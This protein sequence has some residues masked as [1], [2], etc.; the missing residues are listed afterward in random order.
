[1]R[2]K[3]KALVFGSVFFSIAAVLLLTTGSFGSDDAG[4]WRRHERQAP[5]KEIGG[6]RMLPGG[7]LLAAS[8]GSFH[9]YDG[10]HWK[11]YSYESSILSN[12]IPFFSDSSGKLYFNDDG[13]AVWDD[14]KITRYDSIRL[15][16]PLTAAQAGNGPVYFG[17]YYQDTGGVYRFDGNT[18][19]RIYD[20]QVRSLAVDGEGNV[21]ASAVP[22]GESNMRLLMYGNGTWSDRTAEIE[23]LLP[24]LEKSL[25]VQAAPDG[26]VWVCNKGPYGV[27]REGK[28][29][30]FE[31]VGSCVPV[32]LG[33]DHKGGVW[34]YSPG[35][36]YH[37]DAQ[38]KWTAN[39][40]YQT[41]LPANIS[42][43][44]ASD[45]A[46]YTFQSPDSVL[47]STNSG[48]NWD[49]VPDPYDLGS[50]IVTCV[51]YLNDGR[52]LCGHGVK[53]GGWEN[54]EKRGLS[55][56]D[57]KTWKNFSEFGTYSF[58][59]VYLMK[60]SPLGL[61]YFYSDG[62]YFTYDG[63]TVDAVDS[64]GTDVDATDM[65]WDTNGVLW[66]ATGNGLVDMRDPMHY[67]HFTDVFDSYR[68]VYNICIDD[69]DKMYM[70]T[71]STQ[72]IMTDLANWYQYVPGAGRAV[73]D[74]AVEG[75]GK[76]WGARTTDLAWW[77]VTYQQWRP[78][79]DF[80]DSNR[81]AMIDPQGRIWASGYGKTGYY[82]DGVFRSFPELARSASNTMDFAEDGRIALNSFNRV[83]S[84]YY[85]IEEFIPSTVGV[86]EPPRPAP[87]LT[88]SSYPN[89]FNPATTIQFDL[90]AA[91]QVKIT[92]YNVTG[93]RVKQLADRRFPAGVNRVE[94]DSR[95]DS[96]GMASSGVYFYRIET[97][98]QVKTGKMLLMR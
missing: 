44:A 10:T 72:V 68:F 63:R 26:S 54:S 4:F 17:S 97:G 66:L 15:I 35:N 50:N 8:S 55:I 69:A 52:L 45:S 83:R 18:A 67:I 1:M 2:K 87:F 12:H 43:L 62:G 31:N 98:R 89:P 20:G 9:I 76:L 32:S 36:L 90:P 59:N 75:N 30:F 39:R 48:K 42:F 60:R 28:W 53:G 29:E 93:Q 92:V 84:D 61:V 94:W 74:I 80:P 49:P 70:Q 71:W 95:T 22:P 21:W 91:G 23:P 79:T 16:E 81:M 38:G 78:V 24:I 57:G 27:F 11:K 13:L 58:P 77:D 34:G 73:R 85:G 14:G 41:I 51:A 7:K 96:G 40:T 82:S 46:V 6:V 37:L 86:Q 33:F 64:L 5:T 65:A 47:V 88:A 56:Y 3:V 25:T 19:E